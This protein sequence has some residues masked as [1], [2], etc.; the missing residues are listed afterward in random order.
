MYDQNQLLF[1]IFYWTLIVFKRIY[2]YIALMMLLLFS[3]VV[4]AA[5]D[6]CAGW[7]K[8]TKP[9]CLRIHQIW[10]EGNNEAYISGYAW[11]NRYT[12]TA[13]KIK[14]FNELAWGG[15][16]GKGFY[17][18]E[19]DWHGISAIAFLDSHK[20]LEPAA[21]YMFLKMASLNQSTS[22][23]AGYSVLLTARPD[24]FH[25]IPFPGLLPWLSLKYRSASLMGTYIPGSKGAGN[26]FYVLGKWTFDYG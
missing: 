1:L 8:W 25:N 10:T 17:D 4:I 14:S 7:A 16:L 3:G 22:L 2:D 24:I 26:V 19:G 21:G 15:G 12:Y 9:A 6:S 13:A 20:N 5:S 11:H 18:E 23:G